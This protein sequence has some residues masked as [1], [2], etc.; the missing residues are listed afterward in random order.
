MRNSQKNVD[1][2]DDMRKQ[3]RKRVLSAIRMNQPMS[4]TEI[5]AQTKLSPATVSA[6]TAEL[7][8]EEIVL[9]E[10]VEQATE[11]RRGRPQISLT[12][13]PTVGCVV[14]IVF[15]IHD[16]SSAVYDYA[17]NLLGKR[18]DAF[19]APN[20]SSDEIIAKLAE[21][22]KNSINDAGIKKSNVF[23]ISIAVQGVTDVEETTM[24]W[25]P[26]TE[27]K[28]LPIKADLEKATGLPVRIS[29]DC[30][31]LSIAL[32]N[33]AHEEL[34][35]NF[36]IVLLSHGIGMSFI[37]NSQIIQ[38]EKS[39][40]ME[41]GHMN[42]I[43]DGAKCRCGRNGCIEAY[44]GDYAVVR[45][46]K[47]QKIDHPNAETISLEDLAEVLALA[48][49]GD[50][51]AINAC[52]QAGFALGVGL[53]NMYALMDPFPVA[54]V[55]KGTLLYKYM[56]TSMKEAMSKSISISG[57]SL[58]AIICYEDETEI[59]ELGCMFSALARVD[60]M[61]ADS[62]QHAGETRQYG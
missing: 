31:M 60:E 62:P 42:H 21:V 10:K 52:E 15:Q 7:V 19:N 35:E 28:D 39:S 8:A 47:S 14:A 26:I 37:T 24:L 34:G 40:G 43:Y 57:D 4:R 11:M 46:A 45:N 48:D 56:E 38:G 59:S 30:N 9:Q 2:S 23:R 6:I 55:G 16:I 18:V 29:N 58:P 22:T 61:L 5:S 12:L 32:R 1:R 25:S 17:G 27:F 41:F 50:K 44:A 33:T 54:L 53:A 51:A 20:A 49:K 36:G 13:S 3:N